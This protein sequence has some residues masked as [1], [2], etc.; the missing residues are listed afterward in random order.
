MTM[1]TVNEGLVWN[2]VVWTRW[3]LCFL[4]GFA[5]IREAYIAAAVIAVMFLFHFLLIGVTHKRDIIEKEVKKNGTKE[6]RKK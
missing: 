4:I 6:R 3:I 5:L 1:I 2:T